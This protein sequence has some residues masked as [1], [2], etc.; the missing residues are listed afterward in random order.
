MKKDPPRG[1]H[2]RGYLPH[3]DGGPI[4][5]F[6]TFR[7]ADALPAMCSNVGNWNWS[8]RRAPNFAVESNVIWT[9]AT[10]LVR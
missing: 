4:P 3:Y 1:W 9:K 5:Q 7:L 2:N 6:L 8:R 10:A